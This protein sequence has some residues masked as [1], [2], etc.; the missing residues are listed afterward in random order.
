MRSYNTL[1][2]WRKVTGWLAMAMDQKST[3]VVFIYCWDSMCKVT[4]N[5]VYQ[6]AAL[7]MLK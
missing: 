2:S 1:A 3:I 6:L 4:L 7:N 5:L